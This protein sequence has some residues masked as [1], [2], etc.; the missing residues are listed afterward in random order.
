[1]EQIKGGGTKPVTLEVQRDG[2]PLSFTMTP[3]P[4]EGTTTPLIGVSW[5]DYGWEF[6][7]RGIT[8]I[9]HPGPIEQIKKAGMSIFETIGAIA[10]KSNVRLQHMSGPVMMMRAYYTFFQLDDGWRLALWFSVILNVNLAIL[11][12]LPI[13]PLDGSHITLSIIE[14]IRRR[15]VN[16]RIVELVQTACTIVIIGFMLYIFFYDIQDIPMSSAR[17]RS[18]SRSTRRQPAATQSK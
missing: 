5:D 6:D 2:K 17:G 7:P 16:V 8:N 11:N 4:P 9:I 1:M 15:P 13:P 18:N 10:S 14:A 12:L 3:E